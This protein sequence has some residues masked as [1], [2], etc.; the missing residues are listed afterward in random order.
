MTIEEIKKFIDKEAEVHR[1]ADEDDAFVWEGAELKVL[2]AI[3]Q[4]CID[5]N[6]RLKGYDLEQI[7]DEDFSDSIDTM[8]EIMRRVIDDPDEPLE[9]PAEV[10][11][12]YKYFENRFWQTTDA[13]P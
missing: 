11:E 2:Q 7:L 5:N 13:V 3:L 4:Y 10:V 9:A 1:T 6:I 8:W 12:L